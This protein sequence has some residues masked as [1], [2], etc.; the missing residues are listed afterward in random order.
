MKNSI[1]HFTDYT[2]LTLVLN[3]LK[4]VKEKLRFN[5]I[6]NVFV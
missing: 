2:D 1:N 3:L 4:S 5:W 6:R